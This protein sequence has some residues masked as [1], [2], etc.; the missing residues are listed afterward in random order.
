MD[1]L[2]LF[3]ILS[4]LTIAAGWLANRRWGPE[5][6]AAYIIGAT[7]GAFVGFIAGHS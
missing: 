1:N 2:V 4:V 6:T 7:L 5:A 3:A